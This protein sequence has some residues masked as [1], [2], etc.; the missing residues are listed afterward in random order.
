MAR[1]IPSARIASRLRANNGSVQ[2]GMRA[3]RQQAAMS[4]ANY[5]AATRDQ[6]QGF[7]TRMDRRGGC[8]GGCTGL[9]ALPSCG[10]MTEI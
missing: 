7:N 2:I 9:Q 6:L 1:P 10:V 8:E 5:Q 3:L 4:M